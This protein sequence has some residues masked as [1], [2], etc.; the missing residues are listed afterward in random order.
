[1]VTNLYGISKNV[2]LNVYICVNHAP[3]TI[4]ISSCCIKGD[5]IQLSC[6]GDRTAYTETY[7]T[8]EYTKTTD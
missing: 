6:T 1:M 5:N 4:T 2:S 7:V 8:I 3:D